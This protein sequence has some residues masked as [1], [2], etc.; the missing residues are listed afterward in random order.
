MELGSLL[1]FVKNNKAHWNKSAHDFD[2]AS[3]LFALQTEENT[4]YREIYDALVHLKQLPEHDSAV[5]KNQE[6]LQRLTADLTLVEP[7]EFSSESGN[8]TNVLVTNSATG[9][10]L[11]PNIPGLRCPNCDFPLDGM[12]LVQNPNV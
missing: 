10:P 3:Y 2:L 4:K 7:D 11:G 5:S 6:E 8:N 9:Q 1:A 12:Q